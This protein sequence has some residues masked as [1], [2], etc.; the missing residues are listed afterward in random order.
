MTLPSDFTKEQYSKE[1]S[2][3]SATFFTAEL[4]AV[5]NTAEEPA[6]RARTSAACRL[7]FIAGE[8]A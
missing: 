3:Y 5:K 4:P 8:S 6:C 7:L 2:C 1:D